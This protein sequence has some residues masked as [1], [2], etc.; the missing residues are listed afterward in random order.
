[1]PTIDARQLRTTAH[2]IFTATG[3]T[4]NEAR[5][6]GDALVD[7]NLAGHDS[8]GVMRIPDYVARI[9][10]G[11]VTIGSRLQVVLET[12]AFALVD[13]NWGFGQVMGREAME[14]AIEKASQ[15]AVAAVAGRNFNHMGRMGDYPMMLAERGLTSIM[16]VN[17]HGASRLVAPH[18][19]IERRLS[20][21]PIAIGIP[22]RS[23]TPIV[24]DISTCTIA[25]GKVRNYLFAD[26]P[27]PSGCLIDAEGQPTTDPAKLYGPPPGALLPIAGHKGFALGLVADIL[28]G[29]ISGAGCTRP[30]VDRVGNAFLITVID[31]ERV[32]GN[33]AFEEDVRE[34]VDF[35]KS[36]KLAE[37]VSEILVPGEPESREQQRREQSGISI[38][39]ATW[40]RIVE[41][42]AKYGLAIPTPNA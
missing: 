12:E 35:V 9:K 8:H 30:G 7:A 38:P 20:A 4:E 18:G 42:G 33:V 19:G 41:T 40:R 2:D 36:S 13:G 25:E 5:I 16:F 22:R 34:L 26:E 21:N 29:A 39:E 14:V 3:A 28:A 31:V 24:V 11:G 37:G 6:V 1:M 23:G 10:N 17:T 15:V 32:R 27:V